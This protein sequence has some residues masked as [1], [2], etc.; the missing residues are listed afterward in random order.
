MITFIVICAIVFI[1]IVISLNFQNIKSKFVKKE[2]QPKQTT[3]KKD[4]IPKN[5][6]NISYDESEFLKKN[7]LN[8][9]KEQNDDSQYVVQSFLEANEEELQ[10]LE[11]KKKQGG[12]RLK[13]A[14]KS[15]DN[16]DVQVEDVDFDEDNFDEDDFGESLIDFDNS[17]PQ[18]SK[19]IQNLPPEIK[20]ILISDVL[21][22]KDD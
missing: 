13:G 16:I 20:A 10:E 8:H 19:Q 6:T 17:K 22:K 3:E 18:I 2:K 14:I 12:G 5:D 7:N 15:I 21:K 1:V 4:V 9:E 11:S